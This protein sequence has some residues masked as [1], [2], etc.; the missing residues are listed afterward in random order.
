MPSKLLNKASFNND[1]GIF[2]NR[3]VCAMVAAIFLITGCSMVGPDFV[4]PEAPVETEWL[5]A[6]DPEIKTAPSDYK[7]WW[8]AFHDPVLD[9]LVEIAYQQN[10]PLQISGIRI[11][12]A[13]AQLGVIVGD[14]YPKSGAGTAELLYETAANAIVHTV[15]GSHLEGCGSADGKCH[16]ASGLEARFMAEVGRAVTAQRLDLSQANELVLALLEKYEFLFQS[17]ASDNNGLP[18]DAV[19]D[20]ETL[21]PTSAWQATYDETKQVVREMGLSAL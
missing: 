4:K 8:S 6:R 14:I 11:L 3:L 15:S 2:C 17:E 10:L 12:Q 21:L 5:E 19:Y 7:A 20:L 9:R 13:R 18:F 1:C 16:H